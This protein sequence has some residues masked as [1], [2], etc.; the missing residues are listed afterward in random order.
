MHTVR[1]LTALT[2]FDRDRPRAE[3]LLS[4]LE[5]ELPGGTCGVLMTSRL[6]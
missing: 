4:E 2:V 3:K 6:P 1:P 5:G